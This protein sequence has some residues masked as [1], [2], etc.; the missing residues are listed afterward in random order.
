MFLF[1]YVLTVNPERNADIKRKE[2]SNQRLSFNPIIKNA[3]SWN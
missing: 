3:E 1:Y 2:M